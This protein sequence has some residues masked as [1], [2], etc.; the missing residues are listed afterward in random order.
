MRVTLGSSIQSRTLWEKEGKQIL[1]EIVSERKIKA[2]STLEMLFWK[3][4]EGHSFHWE[5]WQVFWQS[6]LPRQRLKFF[7]W[8]SHYSCNQALPI[9]ALKCWYFKRNKQ[10]PFYFFESQLLFVTVLFCFVCFLFFFGGW[11][12]VRFLIHKRLIIL[13]SSDGGK[14]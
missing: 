5:K 2:S 8:Q 11:G 3:W 4:S 6:L 14:S 13:K 9:D 7:T 10:L 1:S 12:F